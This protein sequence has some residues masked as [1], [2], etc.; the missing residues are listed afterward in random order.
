MDSQLGKR[1]AVG[2]NVEE[3]ADGNRISRLRN[4]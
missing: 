2:A 1:I 4:L 3:P